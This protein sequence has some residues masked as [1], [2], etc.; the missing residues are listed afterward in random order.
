MGRRTRKEKRRSDGGSDGLLLL[1]PTSEGQAT[2]QKVTSACSCA[3]D[4]LLFTVLCT[5]A[6]LHFSLPQMAFALINW[7]GLVKEATIE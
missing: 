7:P 3:R 2:I 1:L 5:T 6:G 4:L